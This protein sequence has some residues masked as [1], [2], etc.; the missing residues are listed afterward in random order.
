[1]ALHE[2]DGGFV[3]PNPWDA[4]SALLC[5]EAGFEALGTSSAAI[6]FSLGRPDGAHRVTRQEHLQNAVLIGTMTGLPVNGDTEDGFGPD[7]ADAVATVEAAVAAGL[8]GVAIEDTTGD[9][10]R[11]IHAFDDAVERVR[12]A[13]KAARGRIVLTGRTDNFLQGIDDL[14]DTIRRLVAFAEVG[15]DVLYAPY[16]S[17]MDAIRAIVKAVAPKP[18]NVVMGPACGPVPV[19]ELRAAGVKRISLGAAGYTNAMA[20]VRASLAEAAA[21]NMIPVS[22]G[23]RAQ[24]ITKMIEKAIAVSP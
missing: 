5:K 19:A 22:T 9:S 17:D 8:A 18:V 1:K 12:Q 2:R 7:P 21:G 15:A 24:A 16:P 20:T 13:A 6:A 3:M 11:P 23:L 14:D 4:V 10:T